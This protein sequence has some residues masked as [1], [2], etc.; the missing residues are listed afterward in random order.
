[1]A[2]V[3]QPQETF[4][5]VGDPKGLGMILCWRDTDGWI[6][7]L[8]GTFGSYA[9]IGGR[10]LTKVIRTRFKSSSGFRPD[11]RSTEIA[12]QRRFGLRRRFSRT[13]K[14]AVSTTRFQRRGPNNPKYLME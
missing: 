11:K 9:D 3:R 12:Q 7:C 10:C 4:S 2:N 14:K 8:N 6:S 5:A 1:M 13:S